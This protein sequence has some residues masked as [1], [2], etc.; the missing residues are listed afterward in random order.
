MRKAWCFSHE[1]K[2]FNLGKF[3]YRLVYAAFIPPILVVVVFSF[4]ANTTRTATMTFTGF[5]FSGIK[6]C[7]TPSAALACAVT[8][9]K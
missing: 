5:R 3:I 2:E 9:L 4:N 8:S 6:T 1:K 7:L